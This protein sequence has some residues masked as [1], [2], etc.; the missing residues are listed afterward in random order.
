MEWCFLWPSTV[1]CNFTPKKLKS[2]CFQWMLFFST[3]LHR[4]R[5][6]ETDRRP[7][8]NTI[9]ITIPSIL[10]TN[11]Y[12][13]VFGINSHRLMSK[14]AYR[15]LLKDWYTSHNIIFSLLITTNKQFKSSWFMLWLNSNLSMIQ[16]HNSLDYIFILLD[17]IF[18]L[19]ILN[20]F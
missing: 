1:V 11:I 18:C 4:V 12:I 2:P 10:A 3:C 9:M 5:V 6:S 7:R 13:N 19:Y 16:T 17:D 8:L 15:A 14:H 20:S